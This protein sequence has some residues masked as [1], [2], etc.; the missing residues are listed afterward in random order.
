MTSYQLRHRAGG[1]QTA[2]ETGIANPTNIII[3]GK[4][5][6]LPKHILISKTGLEAKK[7]PFTLRVQ[8][9]WHRQFC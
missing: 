1:K 5:L 2:T 7:L 9:M 4:Q 3:I 6:T 8:V